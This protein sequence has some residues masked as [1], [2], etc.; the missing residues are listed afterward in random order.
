LN[1]LAEPT[2]SRHRLGLLAA[3]V[4][5][6]SFALLGVAARAHASETMYWDNYSTSDVS[7]ANVNGTGGGAL[8]VTGAGIDEPEGMAYDPANG[9]IYIAS[10]NSEAI[11]WVNINGSGGG[12]LNTGSA[13]V[14]EPA[15]ITI[16]LATQTLYWG[17]NSGEDAIGYAPV[18]GGSGGAL[19]TAGLATAT[20]QRIAIDTADGRLY[21]L[22]S[23]GVTGEEIAYANLNGSGGGLLTGSDTDLGRGQDSIA[24]DPAAQRLYVLFQGESEAGIMEWASLT[25]PEHGTVD[26]SKAPVDDVYGLAFDPSLSRF[27]WAGNTT[28]GGGKAEGSFG[29]ATLAA[30]GSAA[31]NVTTAPYKQ[32]QDAIVVKSPTGAGLPAV[33]QSVA[34]LS[35][36][37]GAW[38]QDYPGSSVYGAP[39]SY[40]YQWFLNGAPVAGATA[41]TLAATAA[42]SYTCAVTGT[43]P[44]GSA[45][46]ASAAATVTAGTLT[47][48]LQTKKVSVKA[49]KAATVK[50]K[51]GNVGD[52]S[53]A[54]VKV[55][56]AK[57]SK[58]AKKGLK[59]PKCASVKALAFGGSAV[60]TLKV[61][62]LKSAKGTFKFTTQVKGASVKALTVKV[63]VTAAKKH[64]AKKHTSKN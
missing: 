24:V 4:A 30:G 7:F 46:Q 61:K 27:Y 3:V 21:W 28:P 38:S 13:P 47:A 17:N 60:A 35:C 55:C 40:G 5:L 16:D 57:L 31:I 2:G 23:N 48:T 58:Q 39:V 51:L 49:G 64:K 32:P 56:A 9:R 11:S 19:S 50:I 33:T 26:V 45:T 8:N 36:S 52:L 18:A 14:E 34:A 44:S 41:S 54:P 42:G 43:N 25:G 37:Q 63:K 62:T 59:A 53:S 6:V 10:E 29:T 15:G 12:V 20:P 1:L 22:Q